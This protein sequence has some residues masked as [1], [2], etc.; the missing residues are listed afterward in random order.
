MFRSFPLLVI[1]FGFVYFWRYHDSFYL[2]LSKSSLASTIL[3]QLQ[4][5][6]IALI[7]NY[8]MLF[9]VIAEWEPDDSNKQLICFLNSTVIVL[10]SVVF[11]Y[12]IPEKSAA[13]TVVRH[14]SKVNLS[15]QNYIKVSCAD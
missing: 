12:W 1:I 5:H 8:Q 10:I 9:Y 14:L 2:K 6:H 7:E 3:I 13:V 11:N 4:S 15:S